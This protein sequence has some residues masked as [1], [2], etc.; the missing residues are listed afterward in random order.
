M[1]IKIKKATL[2]EN[3]RGKNDIMIT[4]VGLYEDNWKF[5]KW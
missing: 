5:I 2:Q 3:K 1:Y 4:M